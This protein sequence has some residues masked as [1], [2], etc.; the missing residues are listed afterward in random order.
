MNRTLK[1]GHSP[2]PDDAFMFYALAQDPPLIYDLVFGESV[3]ND[4]VAIVLFRTLQQFLSLT[5]FTPLLV[6]EIIGAPAAHFTLPPLAP[7]RAAPAAD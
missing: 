5:E 7:A 2:D 6:L 4:A 3:L 1:L